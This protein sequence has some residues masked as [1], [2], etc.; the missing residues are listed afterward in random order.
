[1]N[2]DLLI[3][4][5]D[6]S[7]NIT[8]YYHPEEIHEFHGF[9]DKNTTKYEILIDFNPFKFTYFINDSILLILNSNNLLNV[10]I[11]N[12]NDEFQT[13]PF[14]S[15]RLDVFYPEKQ[16]LFGLLERAGEVELKDTENEYY[17]LYNIDLFE[18][19]KDQYYGLYGTWPFVMGHKQ[20]LIS[21]L[22]WNNPSETYVRVKTLTETVQEIDNDNNPII[23]GVIQGKETVF[24]SES[25]I[26]DLVILS[27]SNINNFYYKYHKLIGKPALPPMFSLGYHQ[28]RWNYEDLNDLVQVDEKFDEHNIPYDTIWLDIE[29]Y[30]YF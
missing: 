21:G 5:K 2:V 25:G 15:L 22:I 24:L 8:S 14:S 13:E 26:I 11:N 18:Y 10:E 23:R 17:R 1:M 20:T 12:E 19:G 30:W 28:S 27:D 4:H 7:L 9:N 3:T 29:V 16:R 6:S